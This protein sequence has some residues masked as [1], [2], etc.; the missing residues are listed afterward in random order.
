MKW[1]LSI[2]RTHC[3]RIGKSNVSN[4]RKDTTTLV[5]HQSHVST[6]L[7]DLECGPTA[8]GH[9]CRPCVDP[10]ETVATGRSRKVMNKAARSWRH[11]A[12][13]DLDL[14]PRHRS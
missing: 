4:V 2:A 13:W 8:A 6:I 3:S 14:T 9:A 10:S 11:P 1:S 7:Y 5:S 12:L